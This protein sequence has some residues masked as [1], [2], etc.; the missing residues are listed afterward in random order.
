MAIYRSRKLIE[1]G[2]DVDARAAVDSDGFGGQT[3]LFHT[4][5]SNANRSEPVMR[6]LLEAGAQADLFLHGVIWGKGFAWETACFDVTPASY[7]Q[8]GLL[9]QFQRTEEDVYGNIQ[10]ILNALGRKIPPLRNVPNRYLQK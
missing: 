10:T 7:A 3:P 6:L 1:L 2:A 8:L 4:V 9:R 5:N